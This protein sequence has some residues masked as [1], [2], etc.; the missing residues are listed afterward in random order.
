MHDLT[1]AAAGD[2]MISRR[3]SA[4][5]RA[6]FRKL[7]DTIRDA[8]ASVVNVE[9]SIHDFE[10][11][12]AANRGMY[13]C[14]PPWAADELSWMGFDLFAAATN[15]T[16]DFSCGGMDAMM[17]VLDD[18]GVAYAGLGRNLADARSPTYVD[19][20]AGR[21]ALVAACSTYSAGDEA[22][23]V[24]PNVDGRPGIA[25]LETETKYGIDGGE[26]QDVRAVSESLGLEAAKRT[27]DRRGFPHP[28]TDDTF[29]FKNV[30]G[31][32]IVFQRSDEQGFYREVDQDDRDAVL[33]R[34]R[35][36][37]RQADW[38]VCSLHS[39]E[40]QNGYF[41]DE[42]VPEFVESFARESIEAGADA[43]VGH[44]PHVVRGIEIHEGSPIFYSL[45]DFILQEETVTRLPGEMYD[46]YGLTHEATPADVYDEREEM[47]LALT[48]FWE[49]FLPVCH[50]ED[51]ELDRVEIHPV[52]LRADLPR[53]RRG[54]PIGATE[55]KAER[56]LDRVRNLSK[57]Y[58]TE[59]DVR[60]ETAVVTP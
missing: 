16:G 31:D 53:S 21:V 8:D 52:D 14:S 15:H 13:M 60:G 7:V 22:G 32:D 44:G 46:R 10:G 25:P 48:E 39:H 5:D 27:N 18:R 30:G 33:D 19:T 3:I 35:A 20:A 55:T 40:G 59:I 38:V 36:A 45:G 34:I 56:I 54:T 23:P 50:F 12:P 1:L 24:G 26:F 47:L 17:D 49:S 42:S 37:D 28:D 43:F 58:R 41:G 6:Q 51:G 57:A 4:D 29:H 2:A 11:Y 9:T